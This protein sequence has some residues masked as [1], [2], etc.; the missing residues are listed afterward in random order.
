MFRISNV[1]INNFMSFKNN[2]QISNIDPITVLVG[3]NNAGKTN[4]IRALRLYQELCLLERNRKI[5]DDISQYIH[6]ENIGPSRQNTEL[7]VS[8]DVSPNPWNIDKLRVTHQIGFNSTSNFDSERLY[9][10]KQNPDSSRC[11]LPI[12]K[13]ENQGG[14]NVYLQQENSLVSEFLTGSNPDQFWS[15]NPEG[16][17]RRI[18][19]THYQPFWFHD[20]L[21]ESGRELINDLKISIS[22]WIFIPANRFT[23]TNLDELDDIDPN[24]RNVENI[25]SQGLSGNRIHT[26]KFLE[27]M[28]EI[29]E[30]KDINFSRD[31]KRAIISEGESI[32]VPLNQ[33]GSGFEQ[34]LIIFQRFFNEFEKDNIFFVEEPEVHLH[35]SLQ[36]KLLRII[37]DSSKINQFF[38]TTHST[39]FCRS[40]SDLIQS[41]LVT[42]SQYQTHIKEL[43]VDLMDEIKS[44]L[45]HVNADLF[46]Y[47]AVLFVEGDTED[48]VIPQLA[49]NLNIDIVNDGLR[50]L[51]SK[52]YG[53]LRQIKNILDLLKDTGTLVYALYDNHRI[54]QGRLDEIRSTLDRSQHLELRDFEHS[55]GSNILVKTMAQMLLN[56]NVNLSDSDIKE[57]ELELTRDNK[58]TFDIMNDF[59]A[60]RIHK[61][62]TKEFLG[63]EIALLLKNNSQ[64]AGKSPVEIFLVNI[65]AAIDQ[66]I[67]V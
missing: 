46:G 5:L 3:P 18:E 16:A 22:R 62:I 39:I 20:S 66:H 28:N 23:D 53:N 36:R 32:K 67:A 50:I 63:E 11:I 61:Q 45:G 54:H 17:L 9:M 64:L 6:Q 14:Q 27:K 42:K 55:F 44:A 58:L 38:I 19:W 59:Y 57:L 2:T 21:H 35:A 33:Y 60:K 1:Q 29:F 13:K 37:M 25:L 34:F 26:N 41:Y 40:Q 10:E 30:S 43:T 52:G 51:N 49:T 8:F 56:E 65:H 4:V 47:N 12:F 7:T 31:R 15:N 48:L 24:G